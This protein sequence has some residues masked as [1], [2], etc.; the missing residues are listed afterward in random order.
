MA[1]DKLVAASRRSTKSQETRLR[2]LDAAEKIILEE[3]YAS[4]SSRNVAANAGV[5]PA[6]VHYH[7]PSTT[8]LLVALY[9]RTS[10]GFFQKLLVALNSDRPLEG[11][12]NASRGS[13]RTSVFA[14]YIALANHR[15]EIQAEIARNAKLTRALQAEVLS[16]VIAQ[17]GLSIEE[18]PPLGVAFLIGAVARSLS[19]EE[20]VGI[21]YGHEEA[22]A[23]VEWLLKKIQ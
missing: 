14:E 18:C 9:K 6:V 21:D 7:F 8:D 3:G 10:E 20:A 15:K 5:T 16:D 13:K 4:I 12:W 19:M 23:I 2:L 1:E 11:V 17:S 22:V